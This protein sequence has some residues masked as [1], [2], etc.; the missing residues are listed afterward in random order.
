[1][2]TIDA[3]EHYN[4]E[5]FNLTTY[6]LLNDAKCA[7]SL[8]HCIMVKLIQANA[9]ECINYFSSLCWCYLANYSTTQMHGTTKIPSS[10]F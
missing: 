6:T 3:H 10:L 2:K 5:M 7:M 9:K 4:E 1:M 8:C